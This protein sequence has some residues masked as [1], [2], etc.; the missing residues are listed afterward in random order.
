MNELVF[1]LH[2]ISRKVDR[3]WYAYSRGKIT[4]KQAMKAYEKQL[5]LLN[6]LFERRQNEV[7]TNL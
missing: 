7:S 1:K 2:E 4:P 5:A 3:I 6:A